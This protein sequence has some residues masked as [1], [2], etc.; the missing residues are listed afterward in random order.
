MDCHRGKNL[1]ALQ[2][3]GEP[4][5]IARECD[6]IG[7]PSPA[8]TAQRIVTFQNQNRHQECKTSRDSTV[9]ECHPKLSQQ[10]VPA[11]RPTYARMVIHPYIHAEELSVSCWD[12]LRESWEAFLLCF[13]CHQPKPSLTA[14]ALVDSHLKLAQ[15]ARQ[16]YAASTAGSETR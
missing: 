4:G 9:E 2:N 15:R 12:S 5:A 13:C 14:D 10:K 6:F 3:L 16:K 7:P 1:A 8:I 11:I